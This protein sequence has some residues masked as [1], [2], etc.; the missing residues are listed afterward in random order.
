[1]YVLQ[2]DS[3]RAQ[4]ATAAQREATT[5]QHDAVAEIKRQSRFIFFSVLGI[6]ATAVVT[7]S[8]RSS[9]S[10]VPPRAVALIKCR[11]L[12]DRFGL[13]RICKGLFHPCL[14]VETLFRNKALM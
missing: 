12:I 3:L 10:W 5:S 8:R 11:R 2:Q 6:F 7:L 4:I 9:I 13:L 14:A 1:M